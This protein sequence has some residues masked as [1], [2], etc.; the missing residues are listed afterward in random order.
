VALVIE[1][2]RDEIL[3]AIKVTDLVDIV[4]TA[5]ANKIMDDLARK[6]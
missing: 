6:K 3:A 4:K 2:R 1:Q 5:M